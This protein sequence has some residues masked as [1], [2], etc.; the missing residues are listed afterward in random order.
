MNNAESFLI[1]LCF[2]NFFISLLCFLFDKY[3]H[4][5]CILDLSFSFSHT[6][7]INIRF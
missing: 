3:I 7:I 6:S 2:F 5:Y 4:T 1:C